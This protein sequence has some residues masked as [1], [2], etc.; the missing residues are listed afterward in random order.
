M[1]GDWRRTGAVL[2]QASLLLV[3]AATAQAPAVDSLVGHVTFASGQVRAA[4]VNTTSL[5]A[6][7]LTSEDGSDLS[8]RIQIRADATVVNWERRDR[9]GMADPTDPENSVVAVDDAYAEGETRHGTANVTIP[10]SGSGDLL[11]LPGSAAN[12]TFHGNDPAVMASQGEAWWSG[13]ASNRTAGAERRL[14]EAVEVPSGHPVYRTDAPTEWT[15]RGDLVVT[16]W[17]FNVTVDPVDGDAA[18]YRSGEWYSNETAD[19]VRDE[20]L[21][22]LRLS[23]KN[24]TIRVE[25]EE[26]LA[27]WTT[28]ESAVRSSSGAALQGAS[29]RLRSDVARYA[30]AET[31]LQVNGRVRLSVVPHEGGSG[32]A[33]D[34]QGQDVWVNVAP[35]SD[36]HAA[37]VSSGQVRLP[38]GLLIPAGLVVAGA[39]AAVLL[40]SRSSWTD[41]RRRGPSSRAGDE[42]RSSGSDG[43]DFAQRIRGVVQDDPGV[44]ASEAADIVGVHYKTARYHLEASCEDG[45]LERARFG[46][47][48]RYFP[49]NR[50]PLTFKAMVDA[51]ATPSRRDLV[52]ALVEAGDGLH[53]EALAD[54]VDVSSSTASEHLRTLHRQGL[55]ERARDGRRVE[56]RATEPARQAYRALS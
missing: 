11:F 46:N 27:Q 25:H 48:L 8:G 54:R 50:F 21:Q 5:P 17:G 15:L 7:Y 33:S 10:L 40:R 22:F 18:T 12:A 26:G 29:G 9:K 2:V 55:V 4:T 35:T 32:L 53:V 24:A 47:R 34:V 6:A 37:P 45:T 43:P 23:L 13:E 19:T 1:T 52:C 16:V 38:L 28:A 36:V 30:F 14:T 39:G 41:R 31:G 42:G 44:T 20:H 56:Y 51:L 49:A 3:V